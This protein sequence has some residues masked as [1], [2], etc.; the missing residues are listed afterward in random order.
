[1]TR[2]S[3]IA[4]T[5]SDL[6]PRRLTNDDLVRML[7]ERG[8]ETSDAWIVERTGIR[9]RHIAADHELTSDMAAAAGRRAVEAA[10]LNVADLD[11]IIVGT[12]TPDYQFPSTA[13]V[14]QQ[15]LGISS[16]LIGAFDPGASCKS[17]SGRRSIT[18]RSA[19][20]RSGALFDRLCHGDRHSAIFE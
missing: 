6:P 18:G 1:M 17:S 7:A 8:V 4:G 11:M 10:G 3:R 9:R 19:N 5:G 16:S 13:C 15:K 14:L 20:H 2:F 12:I